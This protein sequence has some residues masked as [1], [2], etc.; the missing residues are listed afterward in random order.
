MFGVMFSTGEF[1]RLGG[2]SIR[3][4]RDYHEI[5]LPFTRT[6]RPDGSLGRTAAASGAAAAGHRVNNGVTDIRRDNGPGP[7]PRTPA[8]G[9]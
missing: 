4:V 7:R 6:A 8:S 9:T 1:A 5:Q 3:T 2:V